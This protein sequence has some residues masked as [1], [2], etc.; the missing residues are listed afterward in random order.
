MQTSNQYVIIFALLACNTA[1]PVLKG[2]DMTI[3]R[4]LMA[5][6][7]ALTMLATHARADDPAPT[8]QVNI[9]RD[10]QMRD[11]PDPS[12]AN[13]KIF[14]RFDDSPKMTLVVRERLRSRGLTVTENAA[15]ADVKYQMMGTYSISGRGRETKSGSVGKLL[16]SSMPTE[17]SLKADYFHQSTGLDHVALDAVISKPIAITDL[18]VWLGQKTGVAG[19]FNEMITGN[20]NGWCFTPGCNNLTSFVSIIVRGGEDDYWW[21]QASADSE[22]VVLDVVVADILESAMKPFDDLGKAKAT[23]QVADNTGVTN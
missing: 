17:E 4:Y 1:P 11:T 9:K 21:L 6:M 18:F 22:K 7:F 20:A 13:K 2:I 3:S 15:E 16:E 23:Q 8:P 12:V 10:S 19:R 14:V 5:S